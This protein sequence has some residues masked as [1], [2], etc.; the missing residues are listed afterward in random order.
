MLRWVSELLFTMV[1]SNSTLDSVTPREPMQLQIW[2]VQLRFVTLTCLTSCLPSFILLV[3]EHNSRNYFMLI[4][5]K[6]GGHWEV[7]Q[8][9]CEGNLF[10]S[11]YESLDSLVFMSSTLKQLNLG[12]LLYMHNLPLS[13]WQNST[14]TTAKDSWDSWG[15]LLLRYLCYVQR[16]EGLN[17]FY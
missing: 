12:L 15:C 16:P 7:Q 6:Q 2:L 8:K 10:V 4:G 3:K 11:I 5:R 13:R 9:N 17:L 14:M 1:L